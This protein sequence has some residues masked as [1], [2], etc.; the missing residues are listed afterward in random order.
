MIHHV[1]TLSSEQKCEP[2]VV[3]SDVPAAKE[4]EF[5]SAYVWF[6]I[7]FLKTTMVFHVDVEAL[8]IHMLERAQVQDKMFTAVHPNIQ[9][10]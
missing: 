5:F 7:V 8:Q 3:I 2:A 6:C 4:V 9:T 10:F 1:A